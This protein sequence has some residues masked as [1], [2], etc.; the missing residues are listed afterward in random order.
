MVVL[1]GSGFADIKN[2]LFTMLG[3]AIILN[4]WAVISYRKRS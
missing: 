1:K 2:H 3:F 4:G